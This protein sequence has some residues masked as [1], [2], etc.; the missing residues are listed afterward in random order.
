MIIK[1]FFIT[2]ANE[3][4]GK[5]YK[6]QDGA[7]SVFYTRS[8]GRIYS[9]VF[10]N[11]GRLHYVNANEKAI[12]RVIKILWFTFTTRIYNH[13]TYVRDI[14]FDS[15]GTLY[16]SE[17]TG[18]RAN[19]KIFRIESGRPT[20][21]QEVEL[22]DV[23]G[24]WAGAFTFD[25]QGNLYISNGNR[26]PASVYRFRDG[27]WEEVFTD[28]SEPI[29]GLTSLACDLLCYANWRSEIYIIDTNSGL[30]EL[31]Y[32]N[33][34]HLW[35]SD[36]AL[37]HPQ[38]EEETLYEGT[39]VYTCN[40][41]CWRDDG[42][43][44]DTW[45]FTDINTNNANIA[46]L[47]ADIGTPTTPTT[48]DDEIWNRTRTVWAW[49]QAHGLGLGDP[50][51]NEVLEYRTSLGHWPSIAEFA[52]MFVT[53]GGFLWGG[54]TCMCRAQ[55]LATLLYRVGIS[56]DRM[57][58]A[59][60]KWKPAYSQHMYVVLKLG[61]HWYHVDPSVNIPE[62]SDAPENVGSGS[63]DYIHPN[64]LKLIPGSPIVKPMLVR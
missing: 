20:L 60:T 14:A 37:L 39:K 53:W 52:H 5:L 19:G 43:V 17:A 8:K 44:D 24:F 13:T 50:N 49:L 18:A 61:C 6:V 1:R 21:F 46:A 59:E 56:S 4:P 34:I 41:T 45:D 33:P 62:L 3:S 32:S 35:I 26:I 54:C 23:G 2:N 31:V 57:A 29:T 11:T 22:S 15:N 48:D 10:S 36:I 55:T 51:Y 12:F 16:F 27:S 7:E 9:L 25:T 38:I 47:L 42:T 40:S 58:I 64:K 63:A 30:R 28:D